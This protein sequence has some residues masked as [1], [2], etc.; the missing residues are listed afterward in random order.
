[1]HGG[2]MGTC[3]GMRGC[4]GVWGHGEYGDAWGHTGIVGMY[5]DIGTHAEKGT[6]GDTLGDR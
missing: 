2:H 3:W 4:V 6:N 5:G 1:M